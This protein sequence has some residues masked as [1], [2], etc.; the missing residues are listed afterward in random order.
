MPIKPVYDMDQY[1]R[2]TIAVDTNNLSEC[3]ANQAALYGHYTRQSRE[4]TVQAGL[5]KVLLQAKIGI[6]DKDIRDRA[7]AD[8]KKISE[9]LITSEMDRT[10]E[11]I[12]LKKELIEA[13]A[14]ETFGRD[15]LRAMDHRKDMLIQLGADARAE[16]NGELRM[17][18][19]SS[20]AEAYKRSI[21]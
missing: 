21:S 1:A 5:K 20:A 19:G 8:S 12:A 10:P 15:A 2:D 16:M 6:L 7:I 14:T 11:I 3:F 4:A 9:S 13:E 17:S 18:G